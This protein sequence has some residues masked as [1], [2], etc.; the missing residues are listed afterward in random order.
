M[1]FRRNQLTTL[2]QEVEIATHKNKQDDIKDTDQENRI[3]ILEKLLST[4]VSSNIQYTNEI[5]NL[6]TRLSLIESRYNST[7]PST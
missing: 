2:K 7:F 3:Q 4:Y 1:S 5:N 6:K